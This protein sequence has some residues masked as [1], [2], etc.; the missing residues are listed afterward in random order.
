M[1]KTKTKKAIRDNKQ[2]N[3]LFKGDEIMI[4]LIV[5]NYLSKHLDIPIV[6]EHQKKST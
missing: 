3:T 6:F 4:E 5:K 2:N 1:I